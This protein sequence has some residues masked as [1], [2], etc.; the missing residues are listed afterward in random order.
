VEGNR[1]RGEIEKEKWEERR[2]GE[3]ENETWVERRRGRYRGKR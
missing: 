2:K 1:Q 3:T